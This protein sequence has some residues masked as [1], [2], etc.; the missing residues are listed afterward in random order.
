MTA[1]SRRDLHSRSAHVGR[2]S[3]VPCVVWHRRDSDSVSRCLSNNMGLWHRMIP[4][5][6]AGDYPAVR[7]PH[8]LKKRARDLL[9]MAAC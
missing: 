9:V 1:S 3:S 4:E 5:R 2:L 6:F 7:S 8:R